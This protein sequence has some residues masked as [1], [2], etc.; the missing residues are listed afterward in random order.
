[1]REYSASALVCLLHTDILGSAPAS[2]EII[3]GYPALVDYARRIHDKYF[4]DY[5]LWE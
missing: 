2:K 4:P 1:M 3:K 5:E